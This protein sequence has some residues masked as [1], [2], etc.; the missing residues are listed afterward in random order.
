MTQI[1]F[2]F[3]LSFLFDF[4]S[5]FLFLVLTFCFSLLCVCFVYVRYLL[6]P[7][8]IWISKRNS[9]IACVPLR[10]TRIVDVFVVEQ[11][12]TKK[13]KKK[14][15]NRPQRKVRT[16]SFAAGPLFTHNIKKKKKKNTI[17]TISYFVF[18]N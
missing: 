4:I 1:P 11:Y 9:A 16:R 14:T 10:A 15:R 13:E 17:H 5:C 12:D 3:F 18:I 2:F 6:T 7:K 8:F